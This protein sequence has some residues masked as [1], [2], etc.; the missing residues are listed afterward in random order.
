[1][2]L[3]T[4]EM[5]QWI[6]T[7]TGEYNNLLATAGE[8][9]RLCRLTGN[10][11]YEGTALRFSSLVHSFQGQFEQAQANVEAAVALPNRRSF[12]EHANYD[13][14]LVLH[15]L[16]GAL[17]Q[18]EHWA[19]KLTEVLQDTPIPLFEI[20]YLTNIARVKIAR[21]KL[22]EG[23]RIV[24]GLL[25]KLEPD[26][27]L[28][29]MIIGIAIVSGWLQLAR[30]KPE[31]VCDLLD[32]RVDGYR[33]AGFLYSLAEELW[34]RGQA[35]MLLGQYEAARS[36]LRK[37]R[38]ATKAQEERVMQ[39][40]ILATQ[41]ELERVCGN[42]EAAGRLRD[43]ARGV[44]HEIAEHAGDLRATFLAQPSVHVLTNET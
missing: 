39:W 8:V 38:Q 36:V 35:Q 24:E 26:G 18:A 13:A 14:L 11:G 32:E 40:Q 16:A 9:L 28:S 4:Y 30:G 37:A 6:L 43:E 5:R 27:L 3:E 33:Q 21:G 41:S 12:S 44:I 20:Y 10:Q 42:P 15:Y 29:H 19:D 23:Q 2:L 7:L 25:D 22:A 34:L 31:R 1:M 17:D